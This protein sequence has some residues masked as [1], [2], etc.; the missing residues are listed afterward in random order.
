MKLCFFVEFGY[1]VNW[2]RM[3]FSP[4]RCAGRLSPAKLCVTTV[5][6]RRVQR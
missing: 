5:N 3:A 2:V 4:L 1:Q 6:L